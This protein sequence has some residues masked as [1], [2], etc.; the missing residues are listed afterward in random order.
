[1]MSL[2][3]LNRLLRWIGILWAIATLLLICV[4]AWPHR[5]DNLKGVSDPP[6]P[7]RTVSLT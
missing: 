1:M 2:D 5:R 4:A 7:L 6:P 3:R